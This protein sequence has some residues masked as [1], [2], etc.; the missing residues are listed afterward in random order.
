MGLRIGRLARLSAGGLLAGSVLKVLTVLK[1]AVVLQS[2]ST[3][4]I[5]L[6][7]PLLLVVPL[8]VHAGIVSVAQAAQRNELGHPGADAAAGAALQVTQQHDPFDLI[9]RETAAIDRALRLLEGGQV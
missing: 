7:G 1:T 9:L 6:H 5:V 4:G 3:G 2:L 8:H